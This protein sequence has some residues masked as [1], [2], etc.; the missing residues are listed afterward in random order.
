MPTSSSESR[1][2]SQLVFDFYGTWDFNYM[3]SHK[4]AFGVGASWAISLQNNKL[5]GVDVKSDV[6]QAGAT[7]ID[8][9]LVVQDIE[10]FILLG[11]S[12]MPTRSAARLDLGVVFNRL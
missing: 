9:L 4:L 1:A 2:V 6:G 12:W 10:S 8:P 7:R 5:N 3:K 11:V